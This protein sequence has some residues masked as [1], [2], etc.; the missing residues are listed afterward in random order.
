ME[1]LHT[2]GVSLEDYGL[3]GKWHGQDFS[4]RNIKIVNLL[5]FLNT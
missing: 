1:F 4:L 2:N 5:Q 3:E